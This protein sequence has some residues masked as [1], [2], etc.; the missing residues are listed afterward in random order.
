MI[1]MGKN[2]KKEKLPK[3]IDGGDPKKVPNPKGVKQPEMTE[4]Q[5]FMSYI[6][7]LI[8]NAI[9]DNDTIKTKSVDTIKALG[10]QLGLYMREVTRLKEELAKLQ[11]KSPETKK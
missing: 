7:N 6:N 3:G 10:Q 9:L 5:A 4:E 1:D 11:K 8:S 2:N